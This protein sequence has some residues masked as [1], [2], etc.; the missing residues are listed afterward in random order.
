ME[1][2]GVRH[3]PLNDDGNDLPE[4]LNQENFI[5]ISSVPGYK[6]KGKPSSLFRQLPYLKRQMYGI[7][8]NMQL[9][10][11]VVF[12]RLFCPMKYL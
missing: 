2:Y 4:H 1:L 6:D 10:G 9:G 7:H 8:G 3:A 11:V 12:L 5:V